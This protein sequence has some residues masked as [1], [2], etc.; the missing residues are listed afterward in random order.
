GRGIGWELMPHGVL[1]TPPGFQGF[2]NLAMPA[3]PLLRGEVSIQRVTD[4]HMSKTVLPR[5]GEDG[6][7]DLG[8]NRTIERLHELRMRRPCHTCERFHIK[9]APHY[10]GKPQKVLAWGRQGVHPQPNRFAHALG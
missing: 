5:C 8:R 10:T 7:N 4:E 3:K 6:R 1:A 2:A 9:G